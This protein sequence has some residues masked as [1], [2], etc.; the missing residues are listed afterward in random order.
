M[1]HIT[2]KICLFLLIGVIC[3]LNNYGCTGGFQYAQ[4]F[5]KDPEL[6]IIIDYIPNWL[7]REHRDAQNGYASVLFFENREDKNY[8]A[9]IAITMKN[10]LKTEIK[11]SDIEAITDD[12]VTKRLKF[13]DA[14]LLS[15]SK[16][17]LLGYEARE[18]LLSYKAMDKIYSTDAKLIPV[19]E[20]ILIFKKDDKLCLLRYENREE[21]FDKFNKAFDHIIKTLRFKDNN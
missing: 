13:K 18:V 8:K 11:L 2:N 7:Y 12:L 6:N 4:Y 20:R 9:K 1:K 5:S 16:T 15:R 3:M 14:K 17:M 19:K 10:G 21:E